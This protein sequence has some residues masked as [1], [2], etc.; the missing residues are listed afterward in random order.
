[1]RASS[2]AAAI[3]CGLIAIV[4]FVAAVLYATGNLQFATS[5]DGKHYKHAV[6]CAALG[7]SALVA[8]SFLRPRPVV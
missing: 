1:M 3:L 2:P 6:L 5:V 7:I 8:A 4:L